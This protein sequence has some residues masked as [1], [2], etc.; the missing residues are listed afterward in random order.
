MLYD[1]FGWF[2]HACLSLIDCSLSGVSHLYITDFQHH[3][4]YVYSDISLWFNR[5]IARSVLIDCSQNHCKGNLYTIRD[6]PKC[7]AA[8]SFWRRRLIRSFLLLLLLTRACKSGM[9]LHC[10]QWPN[11][12]QCGSPMIGNP[13]ISFPLQR[14]PPGGEGVQEK[15]G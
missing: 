10:L 9:F 3:F 2:R 12:M 7:N 5:L 6:P 11:Q 8:P 15:R 13:R 4:R 14:Q 1:T